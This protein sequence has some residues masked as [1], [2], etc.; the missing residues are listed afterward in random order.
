MSF[1]SHY[2]SS[3]I[4]QNF[5]DDTIIMHFIGGH[6][7][8]G[9]I[10]FEIWNFELS[11]ILFTVLPPILFTLVINLT[12]EEARFHP[13]GGF[14]PPWNARYSQLTCVYYLELKWFS[15]V[16][17]MRCRTVSVRIQIKY[18]VLFFFIFPTLGS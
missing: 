3:Y 14:L 12:R 7:S 9:A 15:P 6:R 13:F 2:L 4:H 17:R 8:R 1:H 16:Q 18:S 5:F 10:I 11:I